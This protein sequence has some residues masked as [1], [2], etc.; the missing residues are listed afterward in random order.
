MSEDVSR[1]QK[2]RVLWTV[3]QSNGLLVTTLLALSLAAAVLEGIGLSFILPI[4]EV[5]SNGEPAA[6]NRNQLLSYFVAAYGLLG[7]PFTLASIVVGLSLVMAVRFSLQ[8][9]VSWVEAILET[10]YVRRIRKR[11]F[12]GALETRIEQIDELGSDELLNAIITQIDYHSTLIPR[13]VRFV[14]QGSL[15][16]V[17]LGVALYLA[18]QLTALAAVGLGFV[19]LLIHWMLKPAYAT[20]EE[21]A[22]ANEAIQEV[23]QTGVQ[24]ARDVRLF[25]MRNLV[26]D[27]FAAA[28]DAHTHAYVQLQRNRSLLTNAYMLASAVLVFAL[29]YVALELYALS[30]GSF[31]VFLFAV[32]R[33]APLVSSLNNIAYGIDGELPH[34]VRTERLIREFERESEP[35]GSGT[36]VPNRLDRLEFDN[37]TYAYPDDTVALRDLSFA[38]E[39]DETVAFVGQSGAG[40]STIVSLLSRF[41]DVTDGRILADGTDIRSFDIESWRSTVAVVRQ[42]PFLF[43]ET[44]AFNITVGNPGVTQEELDEVCAVAQI[45]EFLPTLPDGLQTVVGDDGVRLSGGQRQRVALARALLLDADVLVLDEA[46][47]NLDGSL[48]RAVHE[49]LSALD[50]DQLTIIIAHRL[51]TV[52]DADRIYTMDRGRIVETGTHEEL[53]RRDGAYAALY[54]A[55]TAPV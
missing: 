50:R 39:R 32:F 33:L 47:S 21:V 22:D 15:A 31:A 19:T 55:H 43:N 29:I 7:V 30:I 5:A 14:Q 3:V 26:R 34:L 12:D 11:A 13:C 4:I 53:L 16:L 23:A 18:P 40:K 25:T 45:S 1:R 54:A 20:G 6:G 17:Y 37:V 44:L 28:V 2:L 38:V 41:Y 27:R 46:T 9:L 10:G 35:I 42:D 24:G 8:F 49:A 52:A 36:P 48:E 51:S